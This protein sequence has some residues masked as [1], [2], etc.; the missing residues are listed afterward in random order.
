MLETLTITAM[1]ETVTL[2]T[3]DFFD[4]FVVLDCVVIKDNAEDN[5]ENSAGSQAGA[6]SG[7]GSIDGRHGDPDEGRP[8]QRSVNAFRV[9]DS[10]EK[11][12]ADYRLDGRGIVQVQ[13]DYP[14]E[15]RTHGTQTERGDR[16]PDEN[17]IA[18]APY[19]GQPRQFF[20]P[21]RPCVFHLREVAGFVCMILDTARRTGFGLGGTTI[22]L[23]LLL[24]FCAFV[25][26]RVEE[27]LKFMIG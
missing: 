3:R 15:P 1:S 10:R 6:H 5:N 27:F 14:A 2:K 24:S 9:G 17:V 16:Y 13:A 19:C 25:I 18:D 26:W 22:I 11:G 12:G 21:G 7:T 8:A 20:E 4:S 23:A